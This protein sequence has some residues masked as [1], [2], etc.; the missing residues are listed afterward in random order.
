MHCPIT[1]SLLRPSTLLIMQS[2][3]RLTHNTLIKRKKICAPLVDSI[4]QLSWPSRAHNSPSQQYTTDV[5]PDQQHDLD[6][7]L[8]IVATPI[9]CLEDI[10]F[11]A[12]RVLKTADKVLCEDTRRTL[13][14]LNHYEIKV[15]VESYHMHNEYDKTNKILKELKAGAAI[16]L[17][18]DAGMPAINDPG[19]QLISTAVQEGISVIPVPGPSA[20]LT[21]LVASGLDTSSFT[22]CG[23][24]ESKSS[25]RKQQ[26]ERWKNIP[27]TLIFF[28]SP[29]ALLDVL[30]DC[31]TILGA[32]RKCCLARELTKSHEEFWRSTLRQ[33]QEE[34]TSRG[35][36]GEFTLIIEGNTEDEEDERAGQVEDEEILSL[37]SDTMTKG[38]A[39][40]QAS[41]EV[42]SLLNVSKKR[43]YALSLQLKE[44]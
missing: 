34:F 29:H 15:K 4:Y 16:A 22:F 3:P 23:F 10:T 32:D 2:F 26:L 11:R 5:T 7:G 21:A 33:A 1:A 30:E 9:G 13:T 38:M 31:C 44:S 6:T 17:V 25:A 27:S 18:S 40:S 35:P 12:L 39:A 14:L 20:T 42:A 41:K 43:V 28:V 36:R 19:A 24:A 37:L 8:Y